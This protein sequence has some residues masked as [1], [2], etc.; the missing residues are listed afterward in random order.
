MRVAAVKVAAAILA[1]VVGDI[2]SAM[3]PPSNVC[4]AR[5]YLGAHVII[6]V[7][8]RNQKYKMKHYCARAGG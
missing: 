7:G 8:P 1:L 3:F 6:P 4:A 2:A 5:E